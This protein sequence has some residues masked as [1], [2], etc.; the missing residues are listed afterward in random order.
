M[1][2]GEERI[3]LTR[4]IEGGSPPQTLCGSNGAFWRIKDTEARPGN[5]IIMCKTYIW[6]TS[7][8]E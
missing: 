6:E 1:G 7:R 2:R 4:P 8:G 5:Q 3:E